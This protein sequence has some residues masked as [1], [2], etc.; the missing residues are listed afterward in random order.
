MHRTPFFRLFLL[1][2]CLAAGPLSAQTPPASL[3]APA[4]WQLDGGSQWQG[5]H[6]QVAASPEDRV[7]HT[8]TRPVT[9]P[10]GASWR[11]SVTLAA[12]QPEA[13]DATLG[14]TLHGAD[15]TVIAVLLRPRER[16]LVV[17][18]A[19]QQ[20]WIGPLLRR[21]P[22][23]SLAGDAGA[24]H[25]LVVD[26]QGSRLTVSVDGQEVGRSE[27]YDLEPVRIG[28]RSSRGQAL[29]QALTLEATG[30]DERLA[31]LSG[32]R[33]LPGAVVLL[34][35]GFQTKRSAA[36]AAKA[37]TGLFGKLLGKGDDGAQAGASDD[38]WGDNWADD[39]S[40]FERDTGRKRLVLEG[41]RDET[42]AWTVPAS[43]FP[44][45]Y[46]GTAVTARVRV[47]GR[48]EDHR[49]GVM[50]QGRPS[51]TAKQAEGRAL[52]TAMWGEN[53]LWLHE[54]DAAKDKWQLLRSVPWPA[55]GAAEITL[56][57]VTSDDKAWVF[58][59]GR[60]VAHHA[61]VEPL[62]VGGGGLRAEGRTRL[63]A[64]S[65]VISEI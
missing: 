6:L 65:F 7:V 12:V 15:G 21:V 17:S 23:P 16:D 9:L 27:V 14:L 4:A 53:T 25:T 62:R 18:R 58:V 35:E 33:A 47:Q 38:A 1:A 24:P 50:L 64:S 48:G 19:I 32:A 63:E 5:G 13:T 46:A 43:R 37:V 3:L 59:D 8:A 34:Q 40:R 36:G 52:L 11:A 29:V 45:D 10:A 51:A 41:L 55:D 20:K 30:V 44:L 49:A 26:S 61:N 39:G 31:R 42:A 22:A 57:L 56:R 54:Y 60:L 2:L 28:V